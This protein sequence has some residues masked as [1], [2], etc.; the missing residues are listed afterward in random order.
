ML[1]TVSSA[2]S[3]IQ[4][5]GVGISVPNPDDV[6]DLIQGNFI[7]DLLTYPVDGQTGAPLPSPETVG[8]AGPA[9]TQEGILLGSDNAT[10]GGLD[11]DEANVICGNGAQ[12]VLIEPGASGNQVLGNQIGVAGPS[13]DGLY[14]REGNG[15]EGVLIESLG[16]AGNPS[17]IVYASSNV[18]GGAASGGRQRHLGQSE[19]WRTHCRGRCHPEPRRSQLHRGRSRGGYILG[20]GNPGNLADGV[21]I[22]DAPDNQIGGPVVVTVMSSRRIKARAFISRG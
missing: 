7:G 5:C 9:N 13:S 12:G 17:S 18:I 6:G 11:P 14:F 20:T 1:Q 8:L 3:P 4:G 2:G 16:T 22:D 21:R 15:A 10:V 19:L